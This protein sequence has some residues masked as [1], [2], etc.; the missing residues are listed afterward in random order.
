MVMQPWL[1]VFPC[2]AHQTQLILGDYFKENENAADIAEQAVDIIGWIN[3]H[4]KVRE[5]FNNEQLE[6]T[7]KVLQRILVNLTW[8]TTHYLA[9]SRLLEL[10]EP[11]WIATLLHHDKIIAAQVGAEKT[12]KKKKKLENDAKEHLDIVEQNN[13]WNSLR[14]VVNDIEPITYG[15][16]MSQSDSLRLDQFLLVL[17]G[18][19]LHFNEYKNTKVAAG[20]KRRLEKRWKVLDQVPFIV[21]LVLNPFERVDRFSDGAGF[22]VLT[23]N[24]MVTNKEDPKIFWESMKG[25]PAIYNLAKFST[26]L[27]E[28]CTN[29]SGVEQTFSDFS[30]KKTKKHNWLGLKKLGKMSKVSTNLHLQQL[31]QEL[32][33][34]QEKRSNHDEVQAGS[35]LTVPQYADLVDGAGTS[36]D[37]SDNEGRDQ[38]QYQ[39]SAFVKSKAA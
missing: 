20:M 10:Q 1:F 13:F 35:L 17:A 25:D 4:D 31:S 11:F 6:C 39:K 7:G 24:K 29:Q 22:N 30:V 14:D 21:V 3:N 27:F 12:A 37:R 5:I 33:K 2:V 16:N 28:I 32:A 38:I 19:F 8:W 23:L 34:S 18:L 26:T 15:T 36:L 9:F